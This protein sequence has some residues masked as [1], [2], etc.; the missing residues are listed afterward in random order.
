MQ[1]I[2]LYNYFANI[3][4]NYFLYNIFFWAM[5]RMV[6]PYVANNSTHTHTHTHIHTLLLW[7]D[8]STDW[9]WCSGNHFISPPPPAIRYQP[10]PSVTALQ[11]SQHSIMYALLYA[12]F[13]ILF[14]PKR[15]ACFG[16]QRGKP[17]SKYTL[18]VR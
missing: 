4:H 6:A 8:F 15:L 1:C 12:V 17:F 3:K 7:S 5:S 10:L 13:F 16:I 2:A 18:G 11:N 14:E 9:R